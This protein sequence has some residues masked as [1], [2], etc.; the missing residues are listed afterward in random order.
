VVTILACILE[1]GSSNLGG[2]ADYPGSISSWIP[3]VPAGTCRNEY[4]ELGHNNIL[5]DPFQF[6]SHYHADSWYNRSPVWFTDSPVKQTANSK[7]IIRHQTCVF[8]NRLLFYFPADLKI[9]TVSKYC[10][11]CCRTNSYRTTTEHT[12]IWKTRRNILHI[13]ISALYQH[14]R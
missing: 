8:T 6:T 10:Y 9:N 11:N 14:K 13:S 5:L 1:V 2:D 4:L 3:S 7:H 12:H